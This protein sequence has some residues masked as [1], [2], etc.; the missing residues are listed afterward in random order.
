MSN[1]ENL[2]LNKM[3]YV[4]GAHIMGLLTRSPKISDSTESDLP[5]ET[6]KSKESRKLDLIPT[7]Q[8][9][10]VVNKKCQSVLALIGKTWQN[11]IAILTKEPEIEI[12]QNQDR[13]G[14]ISWHVYDPQIGKSISFI[15]ELEM[16]GWLDNRNNHF[17]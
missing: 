2:A 4:Q 16:L 5:N 10:Q 17:Q 11:A 9:I 1:T 6:A 12:W 7:E 15:S 8:S 14:Q 3:F 13:H